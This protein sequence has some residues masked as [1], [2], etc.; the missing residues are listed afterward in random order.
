MI[1]SCGNFNGEAPL[2]RGELAQYLSP[3][4][5]FTGFLTYIAADTCEQSGGTYAYLQ[6]EIQQNSV[7]TT[8]STRYAQSQL[9]LF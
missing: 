5:E 1:Q 3:I 6:T 9:V 7:R 4:F 2:T 8:A